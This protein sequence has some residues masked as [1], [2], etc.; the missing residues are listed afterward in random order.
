MTWRAYGDWG[1]TRLRLYRIEGGRSVRVV[2]GPGIAAAVHPAEALRSAIR[3]LGQDTPEVIRLCGMAGARNGLLE[4]AYAS[5]P[6]DAATW[7]ESSVSSSFDG[8]PLRIGTGITDGN[9]VMRGEECQVFG[10]LQLGGTFG[11]I[12]LP[13][14][15]SKWV[16]IQ[17]DRI[18]GLQTFMTGELFALLAGQS[19]LKPVPSG[20]EA[21]EEAGFEDGLWKG[22]DSGLAANLFAARAAQ[23]LRGLPG[24]WARGYLS[25]LLIGSEIFAR[26]IC[27]P[28]PSHVTLIGEAHLCE[29]YRSALERA[30]VAAHMHDAQAC[31]LKGLELLD[32]HG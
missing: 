22:L 4:T 12:V 21:D 29:R 31:V 17:D 7:A 2:E 18:T 15:H 23:V 5:C 14:T 16:R 10:A 20:D 8:I 19:T 9:D 6:T 26:A 24:R 1:T 28:L 27:A 30:G 11:D 13:G 3:D 32:A 25:G